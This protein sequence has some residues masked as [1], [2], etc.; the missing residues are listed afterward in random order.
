MSEVL[1][2]N[3]QVRK[4]GEHKL[5]QF[6]SADVDKYAGYLVLVL[7]QSKIFGCNSPQKSSATK[8]SLLRQSFSGE[9]FLTL[10]TIL[11]MFPINPITRIYG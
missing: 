5:N 9:T 3:N 4:Q 8:S 6:K 2:N 10:I 11:R 7:G 1:D